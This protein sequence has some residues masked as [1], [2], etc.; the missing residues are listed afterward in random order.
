MQKLHI[1]GVS[2]FIERLPELLDVYRRAFLDVHE[3]DPE[4]A[5]RERHRLMQ[6]HQ[7]RVGLRLVLAEDSAGEVI[8]FC[9]TYRGCPGQWWHDVIHRALRAEE[10]TTWLEDCREIVELHVLPSAQ[11]AGLGRQLLRAALEDVPERTAALSA[12]DLPGSRALRLYADEGFSPLLTQF[13]FPGSATPYVILGK[14]LRPQ[15]C[16]SSL[17]S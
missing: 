9:Y 16:D 10:R 12:L 5:T 4:R 14:Q 7:F 17:P 15:T 6:Q 13:R 1:G 11:G 2:M 3:P 8:G